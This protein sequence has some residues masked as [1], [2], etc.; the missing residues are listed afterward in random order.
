VKLDTSNLTTA[1]YD[2][3]SQR[4]RMKVVKFTTER[5]KRARRGSPAIPEG[6]T[7]YAIQYDKGGYFTYSY[8]N[9]TDAQDSA[10][11]MRLHETD[12]M[13]YYPWN[14]V[15]DIQKTV[16]VSPRPQKSQKSEK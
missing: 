16:H 14:V 4:V 11:N 3:L 1:Q 9:Y 2:A 7:L 6:T 8:Q 10:D 12:N 5:P 13:F 15:H